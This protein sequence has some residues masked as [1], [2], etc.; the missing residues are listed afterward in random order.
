MRKRPAARAHVHGCHF[1]MRGNA[2]AFHLLAALGRRVSGHKLGQNPPTIP[3]NSFSKKRVA[4]PQGTGPPAFLEGDAEMGVGT[5]RCEGGRRGAG[6]PAGAGLTLLQTAFT[7]WSRT[8]A[9]WGF[10]RFCWSSACRIRMEKGTME[11]G[12]R[13]KA[14]SVCL[15]PPSTAGS[16]RTLP[17]QGGQTLPFLEKYTVTPVLKPVLV[18]SVKRV[19]Q[20]TATG[21]LAVTPCPQLRPSRVEAT[22]CSRTGHSRTLCEEANIYLRN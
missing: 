16:P 4:W 13:A 7:L 17:K 20:T 6:G 18:L 14:A 9:S 8:T 22:T 1:Y 15:P 3:Q 12:S 11:P 5:G 10:P 19:F 21:G 2:S